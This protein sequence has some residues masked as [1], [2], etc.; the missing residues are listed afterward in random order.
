MQGIILL[1]AICFGLIAIHLLVERAEKRAVFRQQCR[2]QARKRYRKATGWKP[3]DTLN[4]F[5]YSTHQ[6]L[7]EYE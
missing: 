2:E 4:A 6:E 7:K 5:L 1:L 3:L